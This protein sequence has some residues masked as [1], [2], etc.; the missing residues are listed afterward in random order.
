VLT[1]EGLAINLYYTRNKYPYEFH[2]YEVGNAIPLEKSETGEAY[3]GSEVMQEKKDIPGYTCISDDVQK[4]V[5][6]VDERPLQYNIRFFWYQQNEV[7]IK[8]EVVGPAGSGVLDAY[9][10]ILGAAT[11]VA[12][13]STP[14]ANDGFRF[15]GWFLDAECKQP[16]PEEWVDTNNKIKPQKPE[17]SEIWETATYYAK[18]GYD[19]SSM[20]ITK[21]GDDVD[22]NDT[23]VF[24]VSGTGADGVQVTI[25]GTGSVTIN[26]LTVGETYTVTEV[27]YSFRYTPADAIQSKELEADADQNTLTFTNNLTNEK[28]LDATHSVDNTFEEVTSEEAS[29]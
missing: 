7:M 29:E 26:G 8:Y 19:K 20:T 27:G 3:F 17:N 21:A 25:K 6:E 11:G 28:W 12:N 1:A 16:V 24:T 22:Q 9:L 5:I 2:F 18:F 13:G 4:I 15:E 10:E 14:T 23:F